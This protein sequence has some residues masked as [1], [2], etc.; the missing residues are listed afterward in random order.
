MLFVNLS[1]DTE[2]FKWARVW[3]G[4]GVKAQAASQ[5]VNKYFLCGSG[6]F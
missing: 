2:H 1:E 6:F 3:E 5:V 4:N